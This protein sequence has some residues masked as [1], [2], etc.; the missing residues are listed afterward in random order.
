[1]E[2][3]VMVMRGGEMLDLV[4]DWHMQNDTVLGGWT[5]VYFKNRK[6]P[7]K[8]R[9]RRS[10]FDKGWGVWKD[11]PAGMIVKCTEADA[12]RSAFP[13]MLGGMFIAE[14]MQIDAAPTVARAVFEELPP[15]AG[16]DGKPPPPEQPAPKPVP[17]PAPAAA[18]AATATPAPEKKQAAPTLKRKEAAAKPAA[19]AAVT[20]AAAPST[21]DR[22]KFKAMLALGRYT[23]EDFVACA[24][25]EGWIDPDIG[26]WDKIPDAR[27]TEF[28]KPENFGLVAEV[29]DARENKPAPPT[30]TV[31]PTSAPPAGQLL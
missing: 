22:D 8:K 15:P 14:E 28:L 25:E 31:A 24:L 10:R 2:S 17:A 20:T 5:T 16:G 7:M 30:A 6:Y 18:P 3:G 26:A 23:P 19:A 11:D 13:T 29:M 1:M 21:T 27:F 9:L 4:G 12:L